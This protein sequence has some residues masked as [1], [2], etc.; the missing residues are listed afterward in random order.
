LFI[1][2]VLI[3]GVLESSAIYFDLFYEN[4]NGYRATLVAII[5]SLATLV[6]KMIA[7][8]L[9]IVVCHGYGSTVTILDSAFKMQLLLYSVVFFIALATHETVKYL[10]YITLVDSSVLVMSALPAGIVDGIFYAWVYFSLSNTIQTLVEKKQD[11]K[12]TLYK[13]LLFII[14]VCVACSALLIAF[15]FFYNLTRMLSTYW[16]IVS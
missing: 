4:L 15:Q 6:K 2:I 14:L 12:L 11:A 9:V 16:Q 5:V 3:A 1:T 10:F 7:R 13:K 8:V